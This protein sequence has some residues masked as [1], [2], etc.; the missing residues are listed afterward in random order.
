MT[1]PHWVIPSDFGLPWIRCVICYGK[2]LLHLE[3][4]RERRPCWACKASG[5]IH[6]EHACGL[7]GSGNGSAQG[8]QGMRYLESLGIKPI[9]GVRPSTQRMTQLE[10]PS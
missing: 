2:G 1:R 4:S 10:R 3:T 8:L 6:L 7:L 9:L 5:V